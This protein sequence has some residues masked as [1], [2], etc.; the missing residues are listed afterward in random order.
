MASTQP[1]PKAGSRPRGVRRTITLVIVAVVLMAGALGSFF[2]IQNSATK[3]QETDRLWAMRQGAR[4]YVVKPVK[5]ADLL[6]KVKQVLG[7]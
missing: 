4:E 7:G 6:A 1:A 3:N 2:Y 5:D